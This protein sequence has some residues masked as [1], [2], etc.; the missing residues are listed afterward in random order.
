MV[1]SAIAAGIGAVGSIITGRSASKAAKQATAQQAVGQ[2]QQIAFQRESLA[3]QKQFLAQNRADL[4]Q[5]VDAGLIDLETAFQ[6]AQQQLQPFGDIGAFQQ[7]Q[8]LLTRGAG[9]LLPHE[10]RAFGRGVEAL[11][12]GFSRVSGGGVSSRALERA[13]QFGQDFARSRVTERLNQLL[14]FVNLGAQGRANLANLSTGFGQ[15]QA[16]LRLGGAQTAAGVGAQAVP[17]IAATF[18]NIGAGFGNIGAIQAQGTVAQQNAFAKSLTDI[19]QQN[20][21]IAQNIAGLFKSPQASPGFGALP[22]P[23]P[24]DTRGLPFF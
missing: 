9:P 5:A 24:S 18:G 17:G 19:I 13:Q 14:P 12:A 11:Q 2:E 10:E 15:Q 21:N 8:E 4:A 16:Q 1:V 6:Q 7:A 3:F 22:A 23:A 20:P